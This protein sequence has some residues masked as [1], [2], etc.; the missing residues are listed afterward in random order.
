MAVLVTALVAVLVAVLVAAWPWLVEVVT[1]R[2][3]ATARIVALLRFRRLASM[4]DE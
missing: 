2:V 4:D 1:G 3:L